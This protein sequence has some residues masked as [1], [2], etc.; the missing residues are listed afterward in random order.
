MK[1][2]KFVAAAA[3]GAAAVGAGAGIAHADPD[4][5]PGP[6]WVPGQ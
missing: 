4:G 5:P 6:P 3:F 1:L 2:K